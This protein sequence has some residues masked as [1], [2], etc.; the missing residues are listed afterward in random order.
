MTLHM[1]SL[2]R[3]GQAMPIHFSEENNRLTHIYSGIDY[4]SLKGEEND[5]ADWFNGTKL[6]ARSLPVPLNLSP[7]TSLVHGCFFFYFLRNS[8]PDFDRHF[9]KPLKV[10]DIEL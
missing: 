3:R 6:P 10:K 1:Y 9:L 4:K 5:T 7:C 2:L 8:F